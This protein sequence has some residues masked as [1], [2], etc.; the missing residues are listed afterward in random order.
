MNPMTSQIFAIKLKTLVFPVTTQSTKPIGSRVKVRKKLVMNPTTQIAMQMTTAMGVK[1]ASNI[2]L[3]DDF[4]YLFSS[5]QSQ[6]I[7]LVKQF[8]IRSGV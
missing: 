2:L 6:L 5:L 8:F 4:G 3:H 7:N 1:I